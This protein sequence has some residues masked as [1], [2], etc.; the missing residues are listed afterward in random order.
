MPQSLADA[1]YIGSICDC[2]AGRRV[3]EFVWMKIPDAV[4][5]PKIGKKSRWCL[6]VYHFRAAFLRE[7]E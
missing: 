3:P 1:G 5:F 6:R 2:K 4:P 7:Y